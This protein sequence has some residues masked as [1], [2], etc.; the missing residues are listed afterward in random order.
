MLLKL[1]SSHRFFEPDGSWSLGRLAGRLEQISDMIHW[2]EQESPHI[3][4]ALLTRLERYTAAPEGTAQLCHLL[5]QYTAGRITGGEL[6]RA[7]F[8]SDCC[9]SA[10]LY[11]AHGIWDRFGR[12]GLEFWSRDGDLD[13]YMQKFA[14]CPQAVQW[15]LEALD[16]LLT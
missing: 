11:I 8:N 12:D 6:E 4:Q 5:T 16:I 14:S 3:E 9:Y 13:S 2:L 10:G 15:P 7:F 1:E